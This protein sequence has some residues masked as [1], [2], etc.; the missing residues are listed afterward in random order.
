MPLNLKNILSLLK[1][2]ENNMSYEGYTI[3]RLSEDDLDS[4]SN[5]DCINEDE[6]R[7]IHNR[8]RK[9]LRRHSE[10]MNKFLVDE[11]LAEQAEGYNTTFLAKNNAGVIIGYLSLCADGIRLNYSERNNGEI[12][13]GIFPS[14]KIARLAVHKNFQKQGIGKWLIQYAILKAFDMREQIAGVKFIT[15]DCFPHR[16]AF[17][18]N[19]RIGFVENLEV[20]NGHTAGNIISLRLNID[21]Y[22]NKLDII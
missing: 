8:K 14:I 1:E 15:L 21:E 4:L 12:G 18:T 22:F 16:L 2:K 17:Y 6:Y 3:D 11:S 9:E 20:Q 13:Y 7:S 19:E 10:D 5:F